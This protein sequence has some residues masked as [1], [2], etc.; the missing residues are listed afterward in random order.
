MSDQHE[1]DEARRLAEPARWTVQGLLDRFPNVHPF[2]IRD[3]MPHFG[4]DRVELVTELLALRDRQKTELA[5]TYMG[6]V[7]FFVGHPDGKAA[8]LAALRSDDPKVR[9]LA[10]DTF[11][12]LRPGDI[13]HGDRPG[14]LHLSDFEVFEAIEWMLE[15]PASEECGIGLGYMLEHAF[16]PARAELVPL[17]R[18]PVPGVRD[19]VLE[20]FVRRG[21]DGG[22]LDVLERELLG[23][24]LS[25]RAADGAWRAAR[26]SDTFWLVHGAKSSRDPEF[27]GRAGALAA[28]VLRDAIAA[29]D[30][31]ARLD[32]RVGW[33]NGKALVQTLAL[34]RP[35][36]A[37]RLLQSLVSEP[38]VPGAVRAH[39]AIAFKELTG[40]PPRD[41]LDAVRSAV[42]PDRQDLTDKLLEPLYAHELLDLDT[43]LAVL[44]SSWSFDVAP[45]LKRWRDGRQNERIARH[46][47]DRLRALAPRAPERAREIANVVDVLRALPEAR[48]MRAEAVAEL[49]RALASVPAGGAD[50]HARRELIRVLVSLGDAEIAA[51]IAANETLDPWDATWA[52]W[53][54]Q[55]FDAAG[56]A[57]LLRDAGLVD[58]IAPRNLESVSPLEQRPDN[59]LLAIMEKSGRRF[60]F[61]SIRDDDSPHHELFAALVGTVRPEVRVEAVSQQVD[62]KMT[63]LSPSERASVFTRTPNGDVPIDEA[64]LA[65]VPVYS[66]EGSVGLVTF[67]Y[68]NA[69]R[70]FPVDCASSWLDVSAVMRGFDA[71]MRSIGRPERA[72]CLETASWA[73]DEFGLFVCADPARFEAANARLR[74]PLDARFHSAA[75]ATA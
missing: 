13:G 5:R 14:A 69:V 72:C 61:R 48:A 52:H 18:H 71:F 32:N 27:R 11:R 60:V 56:V 25:R 54:V 68:E 6:L 8:L 29:R 34:A 58:E 53:Q 70:R 47:V 51:D 9:R 7:L 64:G 66:T 15:D 42:Q 62:R 22:A 45:L 23:W 16:E 44:G 39:A 33:L 2:W 17:L 65:D 46:L 59:V 30:V 73:S 43:A 55:G 28:R 41:A 36:N 40:E 19:R 63:E 12:V 20:A 3:A 4:G 31:A 26:R 35:R 75:P 38:R 74:L 67:I 50:P 1:L 10:L 24:G 57:D 21:C 37:A 49:R